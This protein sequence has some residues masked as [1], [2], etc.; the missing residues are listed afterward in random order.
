VYENADKSRAMLKALRQTADRMK[1]AKSIPAVV[2]EQRSDPSA[3]PADVPVF[4]AKA[5]WSVFASAA[6]GDV[7]ELADLMNDPNRQGIRASAFA[8]L[9]GL[10]AGSPDKVDAVR[11]IA[12]DRWKLSAA[13]A[14]AL[15]NTFAG[16]DEKKR[17][18]KDAL[19]KL[20]DQLN[21][22]TIAQ[23]EAALFVLLVEVD[24]MA[25]SSPQ[26]TIDVAAPDDK[27]AAAIAAWKRRITDLTKEV[28]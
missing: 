5:V 18:D 15:L 7:A 6:L 17:R 11:T 24:P 8:A 10:L 1:D 19:T 14:D 27:R 25:Q 3:P 20:A 28:K 26:L 4:I 22:E 12:R 21:A 13:D 16:L 9:R 23:R 2:A